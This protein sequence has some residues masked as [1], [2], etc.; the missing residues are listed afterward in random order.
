[1]KFHD[2]RILTP[3]NAA[4]EKVLDVDTVKEITVQAVEKYP[5]E[6]CSISSDDSYFDLDDTVVRDSLFLNQEKLPK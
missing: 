3:K 4:A 5:L 1:M 2:E 6:L